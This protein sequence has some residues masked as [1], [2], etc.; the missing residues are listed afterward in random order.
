MKLRAIITA[1]A[2]VVVGSAVAGSFVNS[3]DAAKIRSGDLAITTTP[4]LY[5]NFKPSIDRY[6]TRCHGKRTRIKVVARRGTTA[7]INGKRRRT[8]KIKARVPLYPGASM[9]VRARKPRAQGRY[10]IRC[11]PEDFPEYTFRRFG[12]PT[13]K[14]ELMT[15]GHYTVIF[16][17][18]GV[19]AW[20]LS[21]SGGLVDAKMLP[22]GNLAWWTFGTP[23]PFGTDPEAAYVEVSLN[24]SQ[25]NRIQAVGVN[26]DLHDMQQL[27]GGDYLVLSYTRRPDV[28]L[29]AY[30]HGSAAAVLDPVIQRVDPDGNLVWS[31]NAK[32]HVG[33]DET[34]RWWP[35][36]KEPSYDI[37]HL[38]SVEVAGDSVIISFRHADAVY[39]IDRST[40][41]INWKLGGTETPKS[42][43]VKNDPRGDYPLNG[44]HD[45]RINKRGNLTVF[46]DGTDPECGSWTSG[47]KC[48]RSPRAVEFEINEYAQTAT[49]VDALSDPKVDSTWC[50]GAAR[51]TGS[52]GWMVTWGGTPKATGFAP[53]GTITQRYNFTPGLSAGQGIYRVVP[54]SNGDFTDVRLRRAMDRMYS[55]RGAPSEK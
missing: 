14:W 38:N 40:G 26:T 24:G 50:C 20:W 3:A 10:E 49:L 4:G 27:P 45:A 36:L 22:S 34:G 43:K 39:S 17:R 29:S 54:L 16:D 7:S 25:R 51:D 30:G 28:D 19:P 21:V 2:V 5:P 47:L 13:P 46:D 42:L 35:Y 44:Q 15:H 18:M 37:L 48:V 8:G 52:Q 23:G 6:V 33:L 11:L 41:E 9:V 1:L 31:W 12:G 32:D 53:D 55:S